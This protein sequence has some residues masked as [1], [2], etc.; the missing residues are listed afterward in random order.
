MQHRSTGSDAL[1]HIS[2]VVVI[3]CAFGAWHGTAAAQQ[4][5]FSARIELR[6][7]PLPPAANAAEGELIALMGKMIAGYFTAIG[8][9]EEFTAVV[10]EKGLRIT[11]AKGGPEPYTGRTAI[12]RPDAQVFVLNEGDLSYWGFTKPAMPAPQLP[13]VVVK[14]TGEFE[15]VAGIRAEHVTFEVQQSPLVLRLLQEQGGD[16]V[17]LTLGGDAWIATQFQTYGRLLQDAYKWSGMAAQPAGALDT[18]G[19]VLRLVLR[20][21]VM[22]GHELEPNHQVS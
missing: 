10:S 20:G 22:G 6:D 18:H 16:P 5:R 12:F 15:T 7:T 17:R 19:F 8:N 9:P 14:H 13:E 21:N 3:V 1:R 2:V 11:Y 4:L